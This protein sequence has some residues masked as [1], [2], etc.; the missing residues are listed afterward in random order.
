VAGT[1][2]HLGYSP[3]RIDPGN[4]TWTFLNTPKV[5]SGVSKASLAAVGDFFDSLVETTVPVAG[6]REA[7]MT[8]LLE[9][10]FRHVNIAL[11]NELAV[12]ANDLG[13][14]VWASLDAAATKP[15]GFL[16][17]KPGPGVGGHCLP[18]DPSYLS[19]RV[20]R[21]LG[22]TFRFVELAN[23]VNEH[24]PDYVVKRLAEGLN[25]A[26][27][28]L[29]GSRVLVLGFAYKRNTGD[30]RESPGRTIVQLLRRTGAVVRV[31]DPHVGGL[32]LLEDELEEGTPAALITLTDA[33]LDAADAVVL[34]TDHDAFDLHRVAARASYVLDTR[35]RIS[36]PNVER[37]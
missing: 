34:V 13:I 25:R 17:F 22:Q 8:K 31:A 32:G 12:Y 3:E 28:P 15:F 16:S 19:W 23:D 5:V 37:L 36:G 14:D 9:N 7:E 33:E 35:G 10:T 27:K 20:R 21:S 1:D 30:A 11:V 2:F 29:N 24:M 4:E 26:R 6:T 18:I